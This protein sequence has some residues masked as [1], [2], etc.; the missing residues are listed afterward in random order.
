MILFVVWLGGWRKLKGRMS[1]AFKFLLLRKHG[2][3]AKV[4][5]VK[6]ACIVTHSV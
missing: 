6:N 3:R 4:E 1:C 5:Q 2:V